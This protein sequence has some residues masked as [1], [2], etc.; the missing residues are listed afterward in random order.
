MGLT[1]SFLMAC[2]DATQSRNINNES[3]SSVEAI[4]PK[5]LSKVFSAHGGINTWNIFKGLY[6]ELGNDNYFVNLKDRSS[7]IEYESHKLGFDG[8]NVWLKN[9][10]TITYKSNPK[11]MY[12]LMFYFYA[13]PFVLGD[14]GINYEESEPLVYGGKEFP[15]ISISYNSGVGTSPD[16]EYILYYDPDTYLMSWLG[17][18]V[19]YFSKEKSDNFRFIKYDEW[20][21]VDGVK[22]P[23]TLQW[24]N[25]EGRTPTTK[26]NDR[27]FLNAKLKID[28]YS[29]DL[30]RIPDT[31]MIVK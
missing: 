18:T 24:F 28:S 8:E 22:L 30:F 15:G 25:Y 17:Y 7:L 16:D 5:D 26:R 23:R 14:D 1:I 20:E 9:L 6:F 10:D 2:N 19:T 29:E 12:N 21:D 13:M 31:T 3:L 11:F 27:V 4:Y